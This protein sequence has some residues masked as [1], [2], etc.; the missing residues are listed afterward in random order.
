MVGFVAGTVYLVID[1]MKMKDSGGG[2]KVIP[3]GGNGTFAGNDNVWEVFQVS[4][5]GLGR[6]M[7]VGRG[8]GGV[9]LSLG[10]VVMF[11]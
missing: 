10:V 7:G 3:V 6:E 9:L 5:G 1:E 8:I 4:G 11:Y 2:M